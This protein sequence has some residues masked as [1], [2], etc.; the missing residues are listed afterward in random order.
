M[1]LLRHED[2][3]YQ[4]KTFMKTALCMMN[5]LLDYRRFR[6]EEEVK[7]SEE[8]A[9]D[10]KK[11]TGAEKKRQKKEEEKKKKLEENDPNKEMKKKLDLDG[12]K[13]L[14]E[15]KDPLEEAQKFAIKV[16][17]LNYSEMRKLGSEILVACF[18]VFLSGGKAGL[19]LKSLKKLVALGYED[20]CG[21]H[22]CRMKFMNY[23]EKK[24][25]YLI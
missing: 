3:I 4:N 20:S 9:Q 19:A 7:K 12:A 2:N 8:A 11:L 6:A 24:D 25:F 5:G 21:V 13:L 16:I 1:Q 10:K 18:K 15:M 14:G 23:G 22:D 17:D